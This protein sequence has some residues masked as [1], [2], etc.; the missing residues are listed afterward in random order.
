MVIPV[1]ISSCDQLLHLRVSPGKNPHSFQVAAEIP[2]P[3]SPDSITALKLFRNDSSFVATK[4]DMGGI[5]HILIDAS[6]LAF[7]SDKAVYEE[8]VRDVVAQAG[9]A[10]RAAVGLIWRSRGPDGTLRI[11]P[12]VWVNSVDSFYY[13]SACGSGS[14]AVAIAESW[15]QQTGVSLAITQPSGD[16]VTCTIEDK[17]GHPN[18]QM[19]ELTGEVAVFGDL[20]IKVAEAL[21]NDEG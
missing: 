14:M 13:E 9:L 4:V 8:C 21:E 10:D 20:N 18:C 19:G 2:L 7:N 16:V 1:T 11:D 3:N 15:S 6:D 12:V 5:V 17:V